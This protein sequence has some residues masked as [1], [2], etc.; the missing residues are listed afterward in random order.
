M[1]D[2]LEIIVSFRE[3]L[4]TIVKGGD[5]WRFSFG[6]FIKF[7][8]VICVELVFLFPAFELDEGFGHVVFLRKLFN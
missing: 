4:Q 1:S 3:K 2:V 5:G 8:N 6:D 7:A